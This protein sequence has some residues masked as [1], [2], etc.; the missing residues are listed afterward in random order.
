MKEQSSKLSISTIMA[1]NLL[2]FLDLAK[3]RGP[4]T[5]AAVPGPARQ[6]QNELQHEAKQIL[7]CLQL[8]RCPV[9][10]LQESAPVYFQRHSEEGEGHELVRAS[11]R[12]TVVNIY[13]CLPRL[14]AFDLRLNW[15]LCHKLA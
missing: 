7:H 10:R 14:T 9:C 5:C 6:F 4:T 13:V 3:A 8:R 15:Q 12:S 2:Q 1:L 11:K